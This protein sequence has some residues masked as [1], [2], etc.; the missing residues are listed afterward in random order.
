M[1]AI[2]VLS[3]LLGALLCGSPVFAQNLSQ[4]DEL[5]LL[6]G[7]EEFISL[8][9]GTSQPISRAPAVVSV[10]TADDIE[11]MGATDLDQILE[12]IPSIHVSRSSL[13][14]K[15]IYVIRGI[16]SEQNPQV[17]VLINGI[18]ITNLYVG[19]RSQIWGGM[20][21]K[22][23][24]RV[25]VIRGPGSALYG[26]DAF[27]G[28]INIVTKT[29][30]EINGT[31]IGAGAGSFDS[32]RAWLLHGH[33][34]DELDVAFSFQYHTTD[35]QREIVKSD[36]QTGLDS[37]TGTSVSNAP[38]P[39]NTQAETFDIRL[40]LKRDDWQLRFGY[41]GRKNIGTGAGV[42]QALDPGGEGNSD[43]FNADLTYQNEETFDDWDFAA[44]LSYLDTS[45]KSDLF[46]F[47]AG[48]T[49]P[50]GGDTFPDSVIGNPDV[51]ERH[52]RLGGSAF[53]HGFTDHRIRLGAGVNYDAIDKVRESKNFQIN[54]M[55]PELLPGGLTET[56]NDPSQVFLQPGSRTIQ[57]AFVQDEW[58]F[59][60]DWDLTAGVRWDNYSDF[61]TTVN[62]RAALVWQSA[63]NLTTKL[64]YGRAFRAPSF[65]ETRNINNPVALGNPDLDPETI[66]TIELAFDYHPTQDIATTL[67]VF[68][69]EISDIIRFVPNN[70]ST[71][72]T[73]QNTGDQ[74]GFGLE[75]EIDWKSSSKH[76][77][78]ANYAFQKSTDKDSNS[79]VA[80]APQHQF[81]VRSDWQ[82]VHGWK[83]NTQVNWVGSRKRAAGDTRGEIDDYTWVDLGLRHSLRKLPVDVSVIIRNLFDEDAREP[84]LNGS[85]GPAIANDL[86]LA[87]IH[88]FVSVEYR[89]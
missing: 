74:T 18:P 84:S 58:Y 88:G 48:V 60:R 33:R 4:E 75:W 62:P 39:V 87:G 25:E 20:P 17:L 53:Y 26:A 12:A 86:P 41:Q 51:F 47:P 56:T 24:S 19:D 43:R 9:T 73:A 29:A 5:D 22:N 66:D 35:G 49:F 72:M 71:A 67:N 46:L 85:T 13:A 34:G 42:A 45:A 61:G 55:F 21:V 3:L 81:Y 65:Q 68:R 36:A 82:F 27:A 44:Q 83:L 15:S 16:Y 78:L 37:L 89:I 8:A 14:Y 28:T 10:I 63:Y 57:Y 31:Q 64:L 1:Q 11:A 40:D 52:A 38:G 32:Q 2:S 77:L 50:F 30:G 6:Y 79:D 59:A 54:A 76:K 70:T 80:N 69:Y 23:I 7:G